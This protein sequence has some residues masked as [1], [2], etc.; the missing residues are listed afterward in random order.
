M[1]TISVYRFNFRSEFSA[2]IYKFSQIHQY[3]SC[4]D[5]KDAFSKWQ[6]KYSEEFSSEEDYL[7]S[8]GYLG[9]FKTKV[10]KS[11]RYYFRKKSGGELMLENEEIESCSKTSNKKST[12][13]KKYTSIDYDLSTKITEYLEENH[14]LKPSEGFEAFCQLYRQEVDEEIAR[15]E[16]EEEE[17]KENGLLKIKKT[18]K[19]KHFNK[20]REILQRHNV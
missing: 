17:E 12:T 18:F 9:D 19:N 7:V 15:L 16:E 1:T 5:F 11:A 4:K 2:L 20:K 6:E 10:F 3:D 14:R 13:R 8:L